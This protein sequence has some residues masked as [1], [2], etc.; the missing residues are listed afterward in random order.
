MAQKKCPVEFISTVLNNP[1]I[2]V[3]VSNV[4]VTGDTFLTPGMKFKNPLEFASDRF[5]NY[6]EGNHPYQEV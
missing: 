5:R 1:A 3:P 4:T 2:T 6:G